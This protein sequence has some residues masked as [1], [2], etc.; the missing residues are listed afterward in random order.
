MWVVSVIFKKIGITVGE[1]NVWLK[2]SGLADGCVGIMHVFD[3][4]NAALDF[5]D[6]DTSLIIEV[7]KTNAAKAEL[8]S[9]LSR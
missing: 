7:E 2:A 5:A 6:Y 4:Y 3:D 8:E 9:L 1:R